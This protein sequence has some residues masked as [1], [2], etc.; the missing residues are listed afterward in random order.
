M[1]TL[2]PLDSTSPHRPKSFIGTL[3]GLLG[4]GHRSQDNIHA[5]ADNTASKVDQPPTAKPKFTYYHADASYNTRTGKCNLRS[6]ENMN[7]AGWIGTSDKRG[8]HKE[9]GTLTFNFIDGGSTGGTRLVQ[10]HYISADGDRDIYLSVNGGPA[11]K[12]TAPKSGGK[13]SVMGFDCE[14]E[15]SGF[16][17][18][19]KNTITFS[20]PDGWGPDIFRI[21]VEHPPPP[22]PKPTPTTTASEPAPAPP[23]SETAP[24][25]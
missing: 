7:V 9:T 22:A 18:G 23:S 13:W 14:V 20:N 19:R 1:T 3:G 8:K 6:I 12:V 5:S 24:A 25:S 15:V 4:H 17:P 10:I 16:Q 2:A 21:G 11:Q